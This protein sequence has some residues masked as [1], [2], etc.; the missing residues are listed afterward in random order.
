MPQRDDSSV[1]HLVELGYVDPDEEAARVVAARERQRR[2]LRQAAELAAQGRL[3][4]AATLLETLAADDSEWVSPRRLLA[5]IYYRQGRCTQAQDQLDWLAFRGIEHPR[6][7]LL[8]GAL[9]LHRADLQSA[10]EWL[11]YARHVAPDLSGVQ[12]LTG[13]LLL[14]LGRVDEAARSFERAVQQNAN[15]AAALAGQAAVFLR[16]GQ[17]EEAADWALRALEQDM[18]LFRAHV[19]LG[20]ALAQLGRPK[21]ALQALEISAKTDPT[22]SAPY[23]WLRRIAEEQLGDAPRAARYRQLGQEVIHHRRER[24][25]SG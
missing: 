14:R 15:D 24:R 11:E 5:E 16:R 1:H 23:R 19:H 8:A 20:L 10:R 21:E 17:Y 22:R 25:R 7:A 3:A 12:T 6:L 13:T 2:A 9:A 4:E 18:Q